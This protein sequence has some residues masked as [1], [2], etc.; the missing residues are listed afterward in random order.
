MKEVTAVLVGAGLRGMD[1]YA[2]YALKNPDEIKF[3]AVA[4]PN[5][6]RRKKFSMLHAI[7]PEFCYSNWED[8]F[9]Q[10]RLAD[11][12][13][14]CTQDRLHYEPAIKALENGYHLLLEKPMAVDPLECIKIGE[15]ARKYR[16]ILSICYVLR[17][18]AFFSTLKKM[19]LEGQIGSLISIQHNENVGFWH[20][21]HSFVRGSWRNSDESSPMILQKSS[22]D[23]DILLWLTECSPVR[24][25]SFGSLSHFKSDNAPKDAPER[26]TD[27]CPEEKNCPYYA[28]KIYLTE[29]TDWPTSA[30]SSDSSYE[31]R[32]MALKTGPYG[33]CVYRCDNNVVDHQVVVIEFEQGLTAAFTMCAFTNEISRTIKLMGTKGQIRGTM[34]KNEIEVINFATG[35][36]KVIKPKRNSSGHSGGDE[37]LMKDFVK[38]IRDN[39]VEQGIKQ[40]EI[41]VMSHIM[42]MAAEKSRLEKKVIEIGDYIKEFQL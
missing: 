8:L 26:C 18:T 11:A 6:V 30:I 27:G 16:R 10:P 39:R 12:A 38:L 32:L 34:E 37:G 22:H 24:I 2:P 29:N 31:S 28:P 20:Q 23:M 19:I 42:A 7:P 36:K 9:N 14:I 25:S 13:L 21:A 5:P 17:Y 15:A 33:R 1:S 3:V 4:E 40:G 35:Q 41:A